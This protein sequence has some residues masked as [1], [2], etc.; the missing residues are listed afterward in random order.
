MALLAHPID[1]RS[2]VDAAAMFGVVSVSR[3]SSV[4]A[5]D[6]LDDLSMPSEEQ[7]KAA[8]VSFCKQ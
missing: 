7:Q 8:D 3:V 4:Y 2:F 5:E 1:R 6:S